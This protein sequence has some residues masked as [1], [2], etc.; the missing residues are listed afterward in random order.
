MTPADPRA[1]ATRSIEHAIVELGAAL[2]ELD[3]L[4][5]QPTTV[6]VIAHVM[7]NYLSVADATLG[8]LDRALPAPARAEASAWI[9]GLRRLGGLMQHTV[10]RLLQAVPPTSFELQFESVDLRLLIT[11]ACDYYRP[12]AEARELQIVCR[13]VGD[14]PPAWADRVATAVVADN[15]LSGAITS[16]TPRGEILVQV[17]SGPGGAVCSVRDHGPALNPLE[18]A[19]LFAS[20]PTDPNL[21]AAVAGLAIAKELVHRMGG[22][23]WSDSLPPHG[24][25]LCFRLPYLPEHQLPGRI[26]RRRAGRTAKIRTRSSRSRKQ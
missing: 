6:G 23:L 11:R 7:T 16:S 24:T 22:R 4:P 1:K 14:V 2:V 21:P 26:P 8:L 3:R 18:Q 15:L 13:V 5:P 9:V 19:T 20:D 25:C 17:T 12:R 10:S